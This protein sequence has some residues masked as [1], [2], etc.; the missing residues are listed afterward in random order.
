MSKMKKI[1]LSLAVVFLTMGLV[2]V[3]ALAVDKK[4][5]D[6]KSTDVTAEGT[7]SITK[8][9]N[10]KVTEITIASYSVNMTGFSQ[11]VTA[12]DGKDVVAKGTV[13]DSMLTVK[14]QIKKV[15]EKKP[16]TSKTK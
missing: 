5:S 9:A 8:D 11:N 6:K 7:L 4:T 1:V 16:S 10:G 12:L 14:G 2:S 15:T 13:K 3:N